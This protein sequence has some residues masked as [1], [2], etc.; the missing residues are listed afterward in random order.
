MDE[1]DHGAV[2]EWEVVMENDFDVQV[3]V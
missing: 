3:T 2:V 1:H